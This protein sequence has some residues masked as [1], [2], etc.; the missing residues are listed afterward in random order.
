MVLHTGDSKRRG[1]RSPQPAGKIVRKTSSQKS[2]K[3]QIL[4]PKASKKAKGDQPFSGDFL[5][6]F[7]F[8]KRERDRVLLKVANFFKKDYAEFGLKLVKQYTA[9]AALFNPSLTAY[10]FEEDIAWNILHPIQGRFHITSPLIVH[11]LVWLYGDISSVPGLKS[12]R[13]E[14]EVVLISLTDEQ[15]EKVMAKFE[16]RF[17]STASPSSEGQSDS[18]PLLAVHQEAAPPLPTSPTSQEQSNQEPPLAISQEEAPPLVP[19]IQGKQADDDMALKDSAPW[20]ELSGNESSAIVPVFQ[21][22]S[23]A[24]SRSFEIGEFLS[25]PQPPEEPVAKHVGQPYIYWAEGP[26]SGMPMGVGSSFALHIPAGRAVD[27]RLS[28]R[29]PSNDVDNGVPLATSCVFDTSYQIPEP[30]MDFI[31]GPYDFSTFPIYPQFLNL[32]FPEFQT[33]GPHLH[34]HQAQFAAVANTNPSASFF[35]SA[36]YGYNMAPI[37]SGFQGQ[38]AGRQFLELPSNEAG[39]SAYIDEMASTF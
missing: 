26:N 30:E 9:K 20:V 6:D 3:A 5:K 24:G 23:F 11:L 33:T 16:E 37:G 7:G 25:N 10:K 14:P 18:K 39:P 15:I 22:Q 17:S 31:G 35:Q 21:A 1:G 36:G 32:D 19:L 27:I 34:N 13:R 12:G 28:L 29:E 8:N 4:T 2:R 38:Q